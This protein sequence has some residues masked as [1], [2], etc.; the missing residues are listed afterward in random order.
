MKKLVS[1][2]GWVKS[3]CVTLRDHLDE[4]IAW[5]IICGY[6]LYCLPQIVWV[7]VTDVVKRRHM[8][9]GLLAFDY[10]PDWSMSC[11]ACKEA[12]WLRKS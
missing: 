12:R 10:A 11:N 3:K 9:Y 8:C 6:L 2:T 5:I 1:D 7:M 4:A